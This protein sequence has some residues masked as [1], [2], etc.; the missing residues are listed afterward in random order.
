MG[1]N[2][3]P[4]ENEA[5][6]Q[7]AHEREIAER[8]DNRV[9][10]SQ[11]RLIGDQARKGSRNE[12]QGDKTDRTYNQ[13][14]HPENTMFGQVDKQPSAPDQ[15]AQQ[16]QRGR[17][18]ET[19][20]PPRPQQAEQL[21]VPKVRLDHRPEIRLRKEWI[22]ALAVNIPSAGCRHIAGIHQRIE[23]LAEF[24]RLEHQ[25]NSSNENCPVTP[26]AGQ[27]EHHADYGVKHQYV[28]GEKRPVETADNEQE[29]KPPQ[30]T[31]A[32]IFTLLCLV[33]ILDEKLNP[34]SREKIA[35]AFPEKRKNKVS[36]TP[37]SIACIN[38]EEAAGKS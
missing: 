34:N 13:R 36:H 17:L 9:H 10:R 26:F 29:K 32:E 3:L 25:D 12:I 4:Q 38:A 15:H 24:E 8:G 14:P 16:E 37:L 2:L 20:V 27:H 23:K 33:V 28:A 22:H 11:H 6:H 5:G 1:R 30:E 18:E 21:A 31:Q 35:Y 19:S 7:H